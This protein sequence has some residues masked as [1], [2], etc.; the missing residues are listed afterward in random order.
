[1]LFFSLVVSILLLAF[2]TLNYVTFDNNTAFLVLLCICCLFAVIAVVALVY[3]LIR[4]RE[5]GK[6][7]GYPLLIQIVCL[8]ITAGVANLA[9][10]NDLNF[11]VHVGGFNEVIA[12][13]E[14]NRFQPDDLNQ[15]ELPPQYKYLSAGGLI[16][17]Q[18]E[19]GVTS[20]LFYESIEITGE[21][22]GYVYRSNNN[23]PDDLSW[24]DA[25]FPLNRPQPNW[26]V[27]VTY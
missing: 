22:Q 16:R 15:A 3:A 26:F 1:M 21:F 10:S 18:K 25:W 19:N 17:L 12:L 24:C 8:L 20:V 5:L 4:W 14:A 2:T 9:Q 11:R 6:R 13:V 7:A 23:P 27:C